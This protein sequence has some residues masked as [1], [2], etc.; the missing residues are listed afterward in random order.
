[1]KISSQEPAD[2][3]P[4]IGFNAC[5]KDVVG[6]PYKCLAFAIIQSCSG[7][8]Q[9]AYAS[10]E[11]QGGPAQNQDWGYAAQGYA[12]NTQASGQPIGF[13]SSQQMAGAQADY[14]A[15]GQA[16]SQIGK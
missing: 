5:Y 16:P 15:Q 8:Q 13:A 10:S 2:V 1:V 3:I 12:A 7:S 9:V 11:T 4:Q 6:S 14:Q